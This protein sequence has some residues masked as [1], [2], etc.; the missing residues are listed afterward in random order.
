MGVGGTE[1]MSRWSAWRRFGVLV[2]ARR[3]DNSQHVVRSIVKC[4]SIFSTIDETWALFVGLRRRGE[5]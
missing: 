3:L 5:K 1:E 4:P 2:R